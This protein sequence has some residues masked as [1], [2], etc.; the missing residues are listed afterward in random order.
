MKLLAALL[1]AAVLATAPAVAACTSTPAPTQAQREDQFWTAYE[2]RMGLVGTDYA[3]P[4]KAKSGSIEYGYF[5]CGELAKGT[6]R[7]VL[8]SQG[9]QGTYT[10]EEFQTQMDTA[11]EFLC[12]E[13]A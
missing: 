9:S 1:T 10:R 2:K 12:P 5:I 13:Q 11:I 8:L 4:A 3:D 7:N 6:D